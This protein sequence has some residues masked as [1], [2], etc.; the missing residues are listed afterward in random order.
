MA[1]VGDFKTFKVQDSEGT[2]KPT[3]QTINTEVAK[4]KP[5]KVESGAVDQFDNKATAE[6]PKSP[7]SDKAKEQADELLSKLNDIDKLYSTDYI[8]PELNLPDTLGQTKLEYE[9]P[10]DAELRKQAEEATL[11]DYWK[12]VEK[13]T[14]EKLKG[15]NTVSAKADK[16]KLS[17]SDALKQIADQLTTE[18]NEAKLDAVDRG[19]ARGSIV[20]SAVD[21]LE[22][23]SQ[24]AQ[25]EAKVATDA[26]I[27]ELNKQLADI[28]TL[29]AQAINSLDDQR[30]AEVKTA[31]TK[32]IDS[33]EAKKHSALKY[34]N[35]ITEAEQKYQVSREKAIA[36]A[37]EKEAERSIGMFEM[38]RLQG[39]EVV[40]DAK[41]KTVKAYLDT[42][43]REQ[44]LAVLDASDAFKVHFGDY[45]QY[46]YDYAD[47]LN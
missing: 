16:A 25:N 5:K 36:A 4:E 19:I 23:G 22:K 24:K 29:A 34:N 14:Q 33:V 30:D 38:Q 27:K 40:T 9:A 2:S 12:A 8:E 31:L 28:E 41:M 35:T 1:R 15:Q 3:K 32:L 43:G 26:E 44:A 11:A 7:P 10:S 17:L 46:I 47:K 37:K 21:E 20:D 6:K 45:Y 42:L 13:I 18:S 39:D